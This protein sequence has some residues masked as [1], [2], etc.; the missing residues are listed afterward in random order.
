MPAFKDR[1]GRT[2]VYEVDIPSA[3]RVRSVAGVDLLTADVEQLLTDLADPIKLIDTLY[4]LCKPEA[5][6]QGMTDEEFGR[7]CAV[8]PDPLAEDLLRALADFF[9][10]LGRQRMSRT[11]TMILDRSKKLVETAPA[12]RMQTA[13]E[14]L[15]GKEFDRA[16]KRIQQ[17]LGHS[18]TDGEASPGSTPTSQA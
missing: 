18:S 7:A 16:E 15:L 10:S 13:F 11:L 3:K 2:W 8:D 1:N 4:G 12:D 9:P 5:D 17:I 14:T 6:L